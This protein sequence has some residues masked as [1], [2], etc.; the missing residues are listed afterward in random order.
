VPFHGGASIS[1][2]AALKRCAT[3]KTY[4]RLLAAY[5][6]ASGGI[7]RIPSQLRCLDG[8]AEAVPLHGGASVSFIAALMRCATQKTNLNF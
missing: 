3:Q 2:I 8:A 7:G 1:F 6:H 4:L 5:F